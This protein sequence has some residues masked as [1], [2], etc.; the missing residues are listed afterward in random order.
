MVPVGWKRGRS[1][2]VVGWRES[3]V[4]GTRSSDFKMVTLRK[5]TQFRLYL[6]DLQ[7]KSH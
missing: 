6:I 7:K 3:D 4:G 1:P 5:V 2:L